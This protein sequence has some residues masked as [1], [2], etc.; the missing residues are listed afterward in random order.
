MPVPIPVSGAVAGFG[1]LRLRRFQFI[2]NTGAGIDNAR[3]RA[4]RLDG[5]R[6]G[7]GASH[8]KKTG[9]E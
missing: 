7:G 9:Q 4:L 1:Y 2:E 3:L 8:S 6:Q 5:R